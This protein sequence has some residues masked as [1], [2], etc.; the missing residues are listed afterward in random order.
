MSVIVKKQINHIIFRQTKLMLQRILQAKHSLLVKNAEATNGVTKAIKAATSTSSGR[1]NRATFTGTT[2]KRG[3][4]FKHIVHMCKGFHR[5]LTRTVY[6]ISAVRMSKTI[7]YTLSKKSVK[8]P[9]AEHK[10]AMAT[11]ETILVGIKAHIKKHVVEVQTQITD[12]GETPNDTEESVKVSLNLNYPYAGTLSEEVTEKKNVKV[13]IM[14]LQKMLANRDGMVKTLTLLTSVMSV[15]NGHD[16]L[17]DHCGDHHRPGRVY[18]VSGRLPVRQR[19]E[20]DS[21]PVF[22]CGAV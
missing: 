2:N 22:D 14:T 12:K 13:L 19:S 4:H 15:E 3:I 21:D 18:R 16:N 6:S 1:S 11:I 17:D 20:G 8:A 10:A 7:L 9:T 5:A